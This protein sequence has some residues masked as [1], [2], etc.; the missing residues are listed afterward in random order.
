MEKLKKDAN[1]ILYELITTLSTFQEHNERYGPDVKRDEEFASVV[2]ERAKELANL[3]A[4][5]AE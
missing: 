5:R 3:K 2:I 1:V 4:K